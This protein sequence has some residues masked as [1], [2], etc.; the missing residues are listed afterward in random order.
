MAQYQRQPEEHLE[1]HL[2]DISPRRIARKREIQQQEQ[3]PQTA[4]LPVISICDYSSWYDYVDALERQRQVRRRQEEQEQAKHITNTLASIK[5]SSAFR[6]RDTDKM[7]LS[8]IAEQSTVRMP[9]VSPSSERSRE[10]KTTRMIDEI[11]PFLDH[12]IRLFAWQYNVIPT[13]IRLSVANYQ[14]LCQEY[15]RQISA[16]SNQRGTF[17]LILDSHLDDL[18][19]VCEEHVLS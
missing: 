18:T 1:D 12:A 15:H 14:Q 3:R 8:G 6:Q 11:I 19:I 2:W 16:Y 13:H 17:H 10:T 9:A 5:P 7:S 4:P